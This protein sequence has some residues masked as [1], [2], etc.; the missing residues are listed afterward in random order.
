MATSYTTF[1]KPLTVPTL[2]GSFVTSMRL[3]RTPVADGSSRGMGAFLA[4]PHRHRD[5][6]LPGEAISL[7]PFVRKE[8]SPIF[9]G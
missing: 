6:G 5:G 4:L 8:G 9:Q 2:M 7:G 3:I 1:P